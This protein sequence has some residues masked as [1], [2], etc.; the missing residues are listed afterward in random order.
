MTKHKGLTLIE[1]LVGIF[2]AVVVFLSI[3]T[4]YQ[5]LIKVIS[6]S[7]SKVVANAIALGEMEKIRNLAYRDIGVQGSFPE[8]SL[9]PETIKRQN[10]LDYRIDRRVDYIVDAKDGLALPEDE[11][12]QDFKRAEIKISW[13]GRFSGEIKLT[14]DFSP[15]SLAEEC[16][17]VGG[18]LS[19]SVFNAQGQMVV[20]P[21]IEVKDPVT[22]QTLKSS[23]PTEG[24]HY[25]SLASGTY[26]VVASKS[27][28]S[29]ER[30]HGADEVTTPEKPNPIIIGEKLSPL[31]FSI[32]Q[33]SSF[34]VQTLA[35]W[36]GDLFIDSF[37]DQSKITQLS[38]V[39]VQGG[40][41]ALAKNGEPYQSAGYLI[42]E[43]ISPLNLSNWDE[44]YFSDDQ[45][46]E[47]KI[48]Y[49]LLYEADGNWTAISDQALPGNEF[50]FE[51]PA[52]N[53]RNLDP[54]IYSR[55]RLRADLSTTDT[56][57]TA[58]LFDW[59]VSWRTS[60]P[61]PLS[62]VSFNLR[63]AKFIGLDAEEKKVFKYSQ[64]QT[65][66]GNGVIEISGLE[67][68]NYTFSVD[69][70]SGLNLTST[71]PSPQ[72]VSLSPNTSQPV[73]LYLSSTDSLLVTL[74]DSLTLE[75]IFSGS[76]HLTNAQLGYDKTLYSNLYGQAFFMPLEPA[77][78]TLE[79]SSASY[80]S[81]TTTFSASSNQM[82][83]VHLER[84]E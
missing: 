34:Q 56:T 68:D 22:D 60:N 48:R 10:N 16:A 63:G 73:K 32:D 26:K 70:A 55:L 67:W 35:G 2:L 30:T 24:K 44:F 72:P 41:V 46:T 79:I 38:D 84:V 45:P 75:P 61:T 20:S 8:G 12:P 9:S 82:K 62:D 58:Q 36:G 81:L 77:T 43:T 71:D 29:Q 51:V 64:T 6:Q 14:S 53:L 28:F 76:I 17:E 74:Q 25:F 13:S 27:G 57:R 31:S 59:Q 78:Y 80:S 1:T 52:V 39:V 11:C 83:T 37:L 54:Q 23:L 4:A 49:H 65:T 66:N 69:P 50:G 47:T 21:L 5:L 7:R 19:V 3:L 42:S 33:L 40:R 15:S 18:I